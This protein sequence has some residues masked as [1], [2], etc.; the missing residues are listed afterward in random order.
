MA[1]NAR[2]SLGRD[3]LYNTMNQ[4]TKLTKT[5]VYPSHGIKVCNRAIELAAEKGQDLLSMEKG[6]FLGSGTTFKF[7][8]VKKEKITKHKV[9]KAYGKI[10]EQNDP[11]FG[12]L[13]IFSILSMKFM[14]VTIGYFY[15][16]S[17]NEQ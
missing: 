16:L 10:K 6:Y 1:N 14:W 4:I 3:V 15:V 5:Y 13:S 17:E 8:F 7:Y 11:V 12:G 2:A 9:V